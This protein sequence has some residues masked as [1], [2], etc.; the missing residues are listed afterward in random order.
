M[1]QSVDDVQV[2]AVPELVV[3]EAAGVGVCIDGEPSLDDEGI[4]FDTT[5]R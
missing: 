5:I 2:V 1:M 3:V 4:S